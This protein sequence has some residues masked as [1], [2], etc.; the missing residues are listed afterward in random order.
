MKTNYLFPHAC[1]RIGWIALA[2]ILTGIIVYFAVNPP[3]DSIDEF[4]AIIQKPRFIL[5]AMQTLTFFLSTTTGI[6]ITSAIIVSLLL[7]AFSREK[8]EDEYISK[9]RGDS[10]VWAM[11]TT[12]ALIIITLIIMIPVY[13]WDASFYGAFAMLLFIYFNLYTILILFL[14]KFNFALSKLNKAAHYEE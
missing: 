4:A 10:L 1:K 14:I 13:A 3:W 11:I 6:M 2:A 9:I 12:Y 7:V 5:A 8:N